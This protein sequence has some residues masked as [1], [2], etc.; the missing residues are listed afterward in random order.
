MTTE[1]AVSLIGALGVLL[2]GLLTGGFAVISQRLTQRSDEL[3]FRRESD[4][5]DRTRFHETRRE[6]YATFVASVDDAHGWML[7]QA[8]EQQR[9]TLSDPEQMVLSPNPLVEHGGIGPDSPRK[10]TRSQTPVLL[11]SGSSEVRR[12]SEELVTCVLTG[13]SFRP[14]SD[15]EKW[16]RDLFV[17][18]ED[19]NEVRR[20][21]LDAVNAELTLPAD[22]AF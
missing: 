20:R 7:H 12:A 15:K 10:M 21:F 2:G 3:K 6:T 5:R 11:I 19:Y 17:H 9:A 1:V 22:P 8:I 18:L 14:S 13:T 4:E 16:N